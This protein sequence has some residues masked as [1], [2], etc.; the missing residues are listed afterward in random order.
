V[1]VHDTEGKRAALAALGIP[2]PFSP[3]KTLR[4]CESCPFL[5]RNHRQR[6]DAGW[7]TVANLRRLWNGLRTSNAPGMVCHSTDPESKFYGGKGD[8]K[9]GKKSECAGVLLLI[10]Q[11][12]NA[13]ADGRPQPFQPPLT[14]ATIANFAWRHVCGAIPGVEDRSED[15]GL[16][17]C[18]PRQLPSHGG[19]DAATD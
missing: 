8:V 19:A 4:V 18:A 17:W 3:G 16:P 13:I 12:M 10:L 14:K 5:K 6:H 2:T 11:N 1:S 7:Y 9:P 15:V